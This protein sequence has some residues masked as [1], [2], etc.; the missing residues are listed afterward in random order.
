IYVQTGLS[1]PPNDIESL[2]FWLKAPKG[3]NHITMRLIDG[4]SQCHQINYRINPDGN[5]QQINFPVMQ[6]FE[7]AGTSSSVEAV[8]RYEGWGGAKDGKWHN[9]VKSLYLLC[10]KNDFGEAKKGSLWISGVKMRVAAEKKEI[11]K[12][13]RLD[14]FLREGELAWSF[15]DGREFPGAK[16]GVSVAKDQ[17]APGEYALEFK[18]D[19]TGGGAYVSTGRGLGG[20]DISVIKMKI[21]TSNT[22]SFNVRL[23]DST[24]QC[25]QAKG[26]KLNPD[27]NWHDVE[28][29]VDKVAGG[30][31]WGG[32]NDGKW[33]GGADSFHILV[34]GGNAD[35]KKPE[36]LITD[37]RA[38]VKTMAAVSGE[39]YIES[40]D[41]KAD[42]PNGWSATGP[43]GSVSIIKD[44]P[45]D[46]PNALRVSRSENQLNDNVT[47]TGA[48]F[49]A[50]PG[51]WNLSGATRSD[52]NSPDSSFCMRINVQMLDAS[53]AK[54]DQMTIVDQTGKKNWKP[55]S[56][57]V[58]FPKGTAK[59]RFIVTV[60]KTFG[61][62]DIDV[63]KA[64]PLLI[65]R[66]EQIVDRIVISSGVV[67]NMF[68][69]EDEVKLNIDV[70]STKPL[71]KDARQIQALI[72]DY[73]GAEQFPAQKLDVVRN[74][75]KNQRFCY[76]TSITLPKDKLQVGKYFELHVLMTMKGF[77]DASEYSA[78]ARLPEAESRKYDPVNIPFTIRNWDSRIRD[79]QDIASRIGHR[80]IGTWGDSGWEHIRDLGDYWY[81]GPSGKGVSEV[82]RKGW[83]NITED[84]LRKSCIDFMTKHKDTKSL[85]CVMLGNE[86][87]ERPEKVAEKV[88]AYKIAYE[89][90]KSVK[91]DIFIV[92]TS[93]PALESFFE[94]G[95][96]KY[97]DAYD[98]HVYETYENVRQGVRRYKEM[99]KK[100]NAEKP[101]WCTELG[102]NSQG[103]TRYAVAKEVVKKITAF[104]AEGGANVSWFGILY[105][106]GNGKARGTSGDAHNTFD[107]KYSK[108]N[109]R[110]DAIM[111]YNMINGITIKKF[112]D[113]VQHSD[114]VQ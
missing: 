92:T 98:Y 90:L 33:H 65:E 34:G 96:H 6:Y 94:A 32:A 18:G 38:V 23:I 91:P 30:E 85:R 54:I 81:G 12:E 63:L 88:K 14:D 5:W 45:F 89:A 47:V 113:E 104:F 60:H 59:A 68:L 80:N 1:F 55:F 101:I 52:M 37:I 36:I 86:P 79:Y 56:K 24:K 53:G 48:T 13:E 83:T 71:P 74:G 15:N 39:Q 49:A 62:C 100:Y 22:K 66:Q 57:Q 19:F 99:A 46:G 109:P 27:G 8:I 107:C 84:E 11:V 7:K 73:W 72:T 64:T 77:E 112:A 75:V 87:N 35:D 3:K 9:P 31:H 50:A 110:L 78:F 10:G 44:T 21:K 29:A 67:G 16:G 106:D 76:S 51:P 70:Q 17:P 41:K 97:T 42:L 69:P 40:F 25:H 93:V 26:F 105:P 111:Y 4:T 108:Y 95:Y 61:S 43:Q 58:D 82:E 102:L 2:S 103:Q 20:A 28:I 114:G